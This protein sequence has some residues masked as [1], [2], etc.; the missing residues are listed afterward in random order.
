MEIPLDEDKWYEFQNL[1]DEIEEEF[2]NMK[3]PKCYDRKTVSGGIPCH[4]L[5]FGLVIQPSQGIKLSKYNDKF[6]RIYNLLQMI[7]ECLQF[8]CTTFTINKNFLCKPHRD[9]NNQGDSIIFSFGD[10][11]GGSLLVEDL[12]DG[13]MY[14]HDIFR[15]PFLFNGAKC[16]HETMPF[17]GTRYS[18]VL[19]NLPMDGKWKQT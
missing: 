10:F 12:N 17:E 1:I 13:E 5:A 14:E 9:K 4:S 15:K 8:P 19:Y 16:L 6:P 11:D 3:W 7:N 2:E 18:I